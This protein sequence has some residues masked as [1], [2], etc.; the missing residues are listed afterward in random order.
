MG[1]RSIE[2]SKR[3]STAIHRRNEIT[4]PR[5]KFSEK[6]ACPHESIG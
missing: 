1:K 4:L 3:L 6:L 5:C 2:W